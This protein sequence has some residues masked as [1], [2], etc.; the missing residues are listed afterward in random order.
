MRKL[1]FVTFLILML[2][3]AEMFAQTGTGPPGNE[4]DYFATI[5]ALA[6]LVTIVSGYIK[7]AFKLTGSPA[8]YL[9][10]GVAVVLSCIGYFLKIGVFATVEWYYIFIYGLSAGLIANGLF[11][12]DAIR[13]L[14]QLF[15]AHTPIVLAM[16]ISIPF[17]AC[18]GSGNITIEEKGIAETSK[19]VSLTY[20]T[21]EETQSAINKEKG[22]FAIAVDLLPDVLNSIEVYQN[23]NELILEIIDLEESEVAFLAGKCSDYKIV[24]SDFYK[25]VM[26]IL[27]Y[28]LKTTLLQS[29]TNS[30]GTV[31]KVR[32][33]L[34]H[35]K[36]SIETK[37]S[38]Y[39]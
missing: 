33:F 15:K 29:Y 21:I 37:L 36:S 39:G 31:F 12:W 22:A 18:S 1:G 6:I 7:E 16:V 27:L 3:S 20:N 13:K 5:P 11:D 35:D 2:F 19:L 23:K 34:I 17:V 24:N 26:K 10:W 8:Q 14:L 28:S 32:K 9:S 38:D 25:D 30:E 4:I